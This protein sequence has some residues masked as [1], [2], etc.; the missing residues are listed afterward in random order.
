MLG[1]ASDQGEA[2]SQ[3]LLE[4]FAFALLA[5]VIVGVIG[6][7]G[8]TRQISRRIAAM[9]G[10][11]Q[12]IIDG[13]LHRRI[14]VGRESDDLDH[15]AATFNRMLDR[16]AALMEAL[17]QVS[18]DI[19][20][21]MRTPLTRLRQRLEGGLAAGAPTHDLTLEAALVDLD[22]ILGTFS[23]LLRIAQIDAGGRRAGFRPVDLV[24]VASTVVDA[25]APSAED[26]G[27]RLTL[28]APDGPAILHGD[29]ELLT[30]MIVNL[31][32]NSMRHTGEGI[33]IAVKA[34]CF[35][36]AVTLAVADDGPGV[37]IANR[38]RLFDRF[39]RLEQSRSTAGNGLGLAL[40]A[41]V[42][43]LHDARI[44]LHDAYPGLEVRIAFP[45]PQ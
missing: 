10:A 19:A 30:Q 12:A 43:R 5:V 36:G 32:E 26:L 4:R 6:G 34:R 33:A 3:L 35:Q 42:A 11:A 31:V 18:V 44:E 28:E 29:A 21:D 24:E 20:H 22:G 23:A 7:Y 37:P 17:R 40:V 16:I 41:S 45:A 14:P 39:Y 2:L 13:D 1:D 8:L 25:F 9:D 38:D 15:L 27:K